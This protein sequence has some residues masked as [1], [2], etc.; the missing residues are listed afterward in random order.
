M[1][2]M[3][4]VGK[5]G[6]IIDTG[7]AQYSLPDPAVERGTSQVEPCIGKDVMLD[8]KDWLA[9][10]NPSVSSQDRSGF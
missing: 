10:S 9:R 1:T 7:V 4:G 2:T 3:N 5:K 6:L 8:M